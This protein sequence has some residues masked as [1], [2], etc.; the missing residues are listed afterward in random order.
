M[1]SEKRDKIIPAIR[2]DSEEKDLLERAAGAEHLPVGTWLRNLG[3][4]RAA[5]LGLG[6]APAKKRAAR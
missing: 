6:F 4:K 1:N 2:C 3:L 5:E